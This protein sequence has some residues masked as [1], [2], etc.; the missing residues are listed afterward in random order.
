[1]TLRSDMTS[2]EVTAW[3]LLFA[4]RAAVCSILLMPLIVTSS[5]LFPFIVGKAIY[6]R[7][8]TEVAF[9][10]W[11]VLLM[12]APQER[13][14]RSWIII[15]IGLWLA[16]SI[17]AAFAGVSPQRSIWSTYERMQGIVD[18]AHWAVFILV[19]SSVFRTLIGWRWVLSINLAVS[20]VASLLGLAQNFNLFELGILGGSAR[21]ESTLGNATYVGAYT[22][23]NILVALGLIAHSWGRTMPQP[24]VQASPGPSPRAARRRRRRSRQRARQTG[25]IDWLPYLRVFWIS[26]IIMEA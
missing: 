6:A 1:M 3:L 25:D 26:A 21:I 12:V 8:V 16:A 15:A 4:T 22:M 5:T 20:V 18:L 7:S 13:P 2:R 17:V 10:L 9:G 23:V 14:K 24:S 11:L 19:A